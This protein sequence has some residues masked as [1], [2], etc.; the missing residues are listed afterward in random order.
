[1]KP[2]IRLP[3][4]PGPNPYDSATPIT[5]LPPKDWQIAGRGAEWWVGVLA[6]GIFFGVMA[7]FKS[8]S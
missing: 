4:D 6:F 2:S 5:S 8:L 1:M 7:Y 3:D